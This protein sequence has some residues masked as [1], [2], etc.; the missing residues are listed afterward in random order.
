MNGAENFDVCSPAQLMPQR[1]VREELC[2][3]TVDLAGDVMSK[4]A[5]F[6]RRSGLMTERNRLTGSSPSHRPF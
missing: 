4:M 5:G 1:I 6:H 3:G 2:A